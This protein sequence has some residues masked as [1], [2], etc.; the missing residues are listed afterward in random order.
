M[1]MLAAALREAGPDAAALKNDLVFYDVRTLLPHRTAIE[2]MAAALGGWSSVRW[3]SRLDP[4]AAGAWPLPFAR[5]AE[6][7][8]DGQ[9]PKAV[10]EI[11]LPHLYTLSDKLIVEAF[12]RARLVLY[13]DGLSLPLPEFRWN[14]ELLRP[15]VRAW[16][17]LLAQ[18][19]VRAH[20]RSTRLTNWRLSPGHVRRVAAYHS[21]LRVGDPLPLPFAD[22]V[23]R[24]IPES[25][26]RAALA[27]LQGLAVVA[28]VA[29]AG[30]AER[31]RVLVLGQSLWRAN[32]LSRAAEEQV[33]DQVVQD[34]IDKGYQV[35]WRDH[36]REEHP[37]AARWL[38]RYAP[39]QF[40]RLDLHPACPVELAV[41]QLKLRYCAAAYSSSLLYL[42]RLFG[43]PGFQFLGRM[44]TIPASVNQ[45][46]RSWIEARVPPLDELP[47]LHV[48]GGS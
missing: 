3:N 13:E 40:S 2:S 21:F 12:P 47:D 28:P 35:V 10:A 7:A 33:Y 43:V 44:G 38:D 8:R 37:F 1:I 45:E 39:A 22:G 15:A 4:T 24:L 25:A 14:W 32:V 17:P 20:L 9:D 27:A 23:K 5:Y 29:P 30:P 34:V 41:P 36:P 11:W 42:P 19:R 18:R 26:L 6:D 46:F 31:P 16:L 48:K